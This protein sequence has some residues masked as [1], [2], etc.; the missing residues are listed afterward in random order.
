MNI[1]Y[2]LTILLVMPASAIAS[3]LQCPN[4][5]K[6]IE[7]GS[8]IGQV[9]AICGTPLSSRTYTKTTSNTQQ[10]TYYKLQTNGTNKKITFIFEN[11]NLVNINIV[12]SIPTFNPATTPNLQYLPVESNLQATYECG[13]LVKTGNN[14]ETVR[15]L[16]GNATEQ[17]VLQHSEKTITELV[18]NGSGQNTLVFNDGLLADWVY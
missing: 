9:T 16:C 8:S 14:S 15:N 18:Y 2:L 10:W 6:F 17:K 7:K 11:N 12:S 5:N 1:K 13:S 3:T 4:D